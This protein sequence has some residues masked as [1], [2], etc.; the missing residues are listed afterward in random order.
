VS[1]IHGMDL[2]APPPGPMP[3]QVIDSHA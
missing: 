2:S 1:D 3:E